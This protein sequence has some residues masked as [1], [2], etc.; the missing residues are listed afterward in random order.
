MRIYDIIEKKRNG[1][2]LNDAEIKFFIDGY[3]KGEIPEYQ[4]SALLM[5]IYFTSIISNIRFRRSNHLSSTIDTPKNI[6]F[7]HFSICK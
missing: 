6:F 2:I 1:H 5:S 7:Y 3:I 4:V